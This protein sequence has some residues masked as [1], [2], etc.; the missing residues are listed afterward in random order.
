MPA[1]AIGAVA[2]IGSAALGASASKK[3]AKKAAAA[4]QAAAESNNALQTQI[5][6]MN[7]GNLSPFMTRGNAAGDAYN[8]LLGLGG[9]QAVSGPASTDWGAYVNGNPDALANWNVVRGSQSDTFGG[10]V[11]AFGQYHFNADGSRR[12][13]TPYQSGGGSTSATSNTQAYQDAFQNYQNSTGYQFRLNQGLGAL[14]SNYRARG[15]S[16]SGAADKAL[17]KYGQ[18]YGSNEFANYLGQ[19]SNQQ[20]V[21]LSAANALAGVGT[22]YAGMVGANNQNAAD[23]AA[24]A[25]IAKANANN[26]LYAG[27]ANAFGNL[28][29]QA[30]GSSYKSQAPTSPHVGGSSVYYPGPEHG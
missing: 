22:N 27:V 4:Q 8:A 14:A 26:G 10:D 25:A 24:N 11:G 13:L 19:L 30:F 21:G 28:A 3:A 1:A 5:Y 6:N 15:V 7:T 23:A 2:S 20:A 29:G 18:D 16:Q 12:D 9:R 17:L